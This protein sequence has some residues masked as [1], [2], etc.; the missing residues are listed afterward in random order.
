MP[1]IA[2]GTLKEYELLGY[3][4]REFRNSL[5]DAYEQNL[6]KNN[7]FLWAVQYIEEILAECKGKY[8]LLK[9]AYLCRHYPAGYRTSNDID[10]LT[11]PENISE[12][13]YHLIKAG[14]QQGNIR[15]GEFV[16]AT[17]KEII[18][19]RLLRG[20]T[21]PYIKEIGFPNMRYIEV[22]IN[23]SVDYKNGNIDIVKIFLENAQQKRIG[24]FKVTTLNDGDFFIHLC[25]HL[26][27]ECTTFP[28]VQMG[29]DMTLYKYSDIYVLLS[30]MSE[31][32]IDEIFIRAKELNMEKICAFCILQTAALF[33][34]NNSYAISSAKAHLYPDENFLHRVISP[35]DQKTF[36][37][38]EKDIEKRFFSSSRKKMLKEIK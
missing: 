18:E 16:P 30:D 13:G 5:K 23:F 33:K 7:S 28:W 14:F 26:Y 10:V 34:I 11:L 4:N 36:E 19:S 12:I 20:E 9:G 3:V 32:D 31:M 29:R 25:C 24:N 21:V 15:N 2:Y 35:R 37:Y 8:A 17:R 22:D 38:T 1:A 6:N 27:K